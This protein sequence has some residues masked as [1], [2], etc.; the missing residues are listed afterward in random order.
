MLPIKSLSS[1][2]SISY[3]LATTI[4]TVACYHQRNRDPTR[5]SIYLIQTSKRRNSKTLRSR[6]RYPIKGRHKGSNLELDTLKLLG[7]TGGGDSGH[8]GEPADLAARHYLPLP[9]ARTSP[10]QPRPPAPMARNEMETPGADRIR[11][12]DRS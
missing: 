6:N 5:S 9:R 12:R 8:P 11:G 4:S 3:D 2:V 10:L 7:H 1:F